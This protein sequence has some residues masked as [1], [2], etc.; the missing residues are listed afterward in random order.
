MEM[1]LTCLGV[2]LAFGLS[3]GLPIAL[4]MFAYGYIKKYSNNT[5]IEN[6]EE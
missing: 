5:Q 3:F 4:P 1:F 2:G 6:K